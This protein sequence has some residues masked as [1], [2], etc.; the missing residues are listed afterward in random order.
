M[1][2]PGVFGASLVDDDFHV[3]FVESLRFAVPMFIDQLRDAPEARLIGDARRCSW[4][5]GERGASLMFTERGEP[6]KTARNSTALAFE[7]VAR[8][9]AAIALLEGA[10]TYAGLHWH[11]RPH[12]DCPTPPRPESKPVTDEEIAYVVGLLDEYEALV[13]AAR[14]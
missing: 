5:V 9:L 1:S 2:A 3:S 6:S 14:R 7:G 12:P 13:K 10:V 11:T 8:G 4:A